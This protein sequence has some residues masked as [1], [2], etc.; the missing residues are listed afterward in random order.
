MVWWGRNEYLAS[1]SIAVPL[2]YSI[3]VFFSG[4]QR[5]RV[6]PRQLFFWPIVYEASPCCVGRGTVV[7]CVRSTL[8]RNRCRL[9]GLL[10]LAAAPSLDS[11]V[12]GN[13]GGI[14]VF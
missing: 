1:R 14:V 8:R 10:V 2:Y 7:G 3:T 12:H 11:G 6:C 4:L 5:L 9:S 13:N